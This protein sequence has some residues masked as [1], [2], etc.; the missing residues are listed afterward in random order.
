MGAY[1]S[2][3]CYCWISHIIES[4]NDETAF[5][6]MKRQVIRISFTS[7]RKQVNSTSLC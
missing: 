3:F 5:Y 1:V 2:F 7:K 6:E 4:V